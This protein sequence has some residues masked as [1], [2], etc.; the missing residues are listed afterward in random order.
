MM[1]FDRILLTEIEEDSSQPRVDFTDTTSSEGTVE[2]LAES[3]LKHGVLQ[4]ILVIKED[5]NKYKIISG[6]RRLRA[7][8]KA[9]Q[10]Q[11][12]KS[13]SSDFDD[14]L[15]NYDYT[16]IPAVIYTGKADRKILQ[17][18]ENIQRKDLSRHEIAACFLEL[19]DSG[20]TQVEVARLLGK[21]RGY[22]QLMLFSVTPSCVTL[23]QLYPGTE[24]STINAINTNLTD[25]AVRQ[26][27]GKWLETRQGKKILRSELTAA[28]ADI[29]K[30]LGEQKLRVPS[31]Q[32]SGDAPFHLPALQIK[33]SGSKFLAEFEKLQTHSAF[34]KQVS[35][36]L[37]PSYNAIEKEMLKAGYVQSDI[38]EKSAYEFFQDLVN[39]KEEKTA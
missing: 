35:V 21:S 37:E 3:I 10:M 28:I 38:T 30:E 4:P 13:A 16:T 2:S 14:F 39:R 9:E 22:V 24:L 23:E 1:N 18:T 33:Y 19:I 29:Q 27:L 8:I 20:L 5:E 34:I 7:A 31:R 36:S 6:T 15:I 26:R 25:T 17:L 11:Q 32:K 12:V